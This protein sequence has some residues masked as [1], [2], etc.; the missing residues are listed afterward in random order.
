MELQALRGAGHGLVLLTTPKRQDALLQ[1]VADN[2]ALPC[3]NVGLELSQR[4][5][6]IPVPRRA[7]RASRELSS[8]F[9]AV[10]GDV[11]TIGN[12]LLFL[13]EL[14]LD[15]LR[16]LELHARSRVI[17]AEWMGTF[18]DDVLTY[19]EPG[20]AEHRYWERP[21]CTIIELGGE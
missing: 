3:L 1:T 11:V 16:A 20:H 4:L 21:G 7:V 18:A 12:G 14:R 19:A 15:P 10:A 13:P 6:D 8:V 5:L 17:I 9:D 2:L